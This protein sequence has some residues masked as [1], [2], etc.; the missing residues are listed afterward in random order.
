[1]NIFLENLARKPEFQGTP[2]Q[3]SSYDPPLSQ[4]DNAVDGNFQNE[5][6]AQ[7]EYDDCSFT[8]ANSIISSA[9]WKLPLR[10]M[11]NVAYMQIYFRSGSKYM[12]RHSC[13]CSLNVAFLQWLA[14][15]RYCVLCTYKENASNLFRR[16]L[17]TQPSSSVAK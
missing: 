12:Y 6:S 2:S 15:F 16:R 4:A 13:E 1:M 3:S 7:S 9:W 11:A 14:G 10:M 5:S 17:T 8:V